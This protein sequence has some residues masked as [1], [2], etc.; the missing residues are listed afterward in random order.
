MYVP[1]HFRENDPD[2]LAALIAGY[3]FATL[4]TTHGDAPFA[5]HLPLFYDPASGPQGTIYGHLARNN[6]QVQD[7]AAGHTHQLLFDLQL[8]RDPGDRSRFPL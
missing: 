8:K 2:R 6:P 5:T 3:G 1:E 4:I 7:L